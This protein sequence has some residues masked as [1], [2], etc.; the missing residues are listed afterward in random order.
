MQT[1]Q[2]DT[3][4]GEERTWAR[5]PHAGRGS[6][7]VV[8]RAWDERRRLQGASVSLRKDACSLC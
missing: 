7:V 2:S 8:S 4:I 5:A 6:P 1:Q 3:R